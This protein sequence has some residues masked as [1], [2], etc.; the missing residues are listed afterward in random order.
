MTLRLEDNLSGVD[1]D[2][3]QIIDS[4]GVMTPYELSN[5]LISFEHEDGVSYSIQ[6]KDFAGNPFDFK[7]DYSVS[8]K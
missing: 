1:W 7:L 5:E 8:E 4:T 3:V 2:S 6:G